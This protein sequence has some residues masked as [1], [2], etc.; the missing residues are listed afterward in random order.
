MTVVA[1][2]AE[3]IPCSATELCTDFHYS[4]VWG[5]TL[6]DLWIKTRKEAVSEGMNAAQF[7]AALIAAVLDS[8]DIDDAFVAGCREVDADEDDDELRDAYWDIQS[9]RVMD[10]IPSSLYAELIW[11]P[12]WSNEDTDDLMYF[13]GI[14]SK[15]WRSNF[16]EDVLPGRW[17][18]TFLKMVNCSS[19]D[20]IG[21]AI[22]E[23][24]SAGRLF[25]EKCA[26]ANFKVEKDQNRM[27]MMTAS[28]VISAI[29]NAYYRAVPMAHAEINVRALFE[30][31]PSKAMRW[32]TKQKGCIHVGFHD[33]VNGAGYM[34]TYPGELI[35]PATETGFASASRWSYG[36]TKSYGLYRPAVKVDPTNVE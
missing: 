14:D 19:V 29:E 26:A 21:T 22:A 8:A 25:A 15:N 3:D 33:P 7:R 20:L 27:Q 32:S 6:I 5:N 31:D 11:V 13:G 18:E 30:L 17:L 35:I 36:I 10:I 23:K 2:R 12:G 16:I 24:G 9:S 1:I 4:D 28:N 34:D